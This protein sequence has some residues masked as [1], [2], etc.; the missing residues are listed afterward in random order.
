MAWCGKRRLNELAAKLVIY[1]AEVSRNGRR[2]ERSYYFC[3]RCSAYHTSSLP[4]ATSS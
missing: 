3:T 1:K 2:G 4:P